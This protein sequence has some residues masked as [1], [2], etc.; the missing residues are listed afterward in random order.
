MI[1]YICEYIKKKHTENFFKKK[2]KTTELYT[3]KMGK[4]HGI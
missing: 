4:M 1:A 3:F 2:K